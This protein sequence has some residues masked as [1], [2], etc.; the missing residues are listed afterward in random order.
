[1][2]GFV[3]QLKTVNI[4]RRRPWCWTNVRPLI[5]GNL[6][7]FCRE[8][9]L[10]KV[11]VR[12]SSHPHVADLLLP[13]ESLKL[14][15]LTLG[16]YWSIWGREG[17]SQVVLHR[18]LLEALVGRPRCPW[19]QV[20][21]RRSEVFDD[22]SRTLP[23][24]LLPVRCLESLPINNTTTPS[25]RSH[26]PGWRLGRCAGRGRHNLLP[27]LTWMRTKPESRER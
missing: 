2:P 7:V 8:N 26:Q 19:P 3:A 15:F 10:Y 18:L 23:R 17:G 11:V 21:N 25:C 9:I 27:R 13:G 6:G 12:W 16:K 14:L 1:M 4:C 20:R 22:C 24:P 5:V